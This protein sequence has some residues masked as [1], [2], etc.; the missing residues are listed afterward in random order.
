MAQWKPRNLYTNVRVVCK[1]CMIDRILVKVVLC[2]LQS[3]I[4]LVQLLGLSPL[5]NPAHEILNR[6]M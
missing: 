6:H 1:I 5:S 4:T 2:S 3:N